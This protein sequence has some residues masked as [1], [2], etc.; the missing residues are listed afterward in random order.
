MCFYLVF[1]TRHKKGLY[2]MNDCMVKAL[3]RFYE[4][5]YGHTLFPL[6]RD[7]SE[8]PQEISRLQQAIVARFWDTVFTIDQMKQDLMQES[9][10]LVRGKG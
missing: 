8:K 1:G 5:E 3:D 2:E 6:F 4:Q 9:T 10:L 7:A